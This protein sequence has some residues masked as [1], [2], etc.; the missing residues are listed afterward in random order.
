MPTLAYRAL[1]V[2]AVA[3]LALA[4]GYTAGTKV[5]RGRWL[6]LEVD[7]SNAAAETARIH[8]AAE[9]ARVR[10]VAAHRF[11]T[12]ARVKAA[13]NAH[14]EAPRGCTLSGPERL[15]LDA[16]NAAYAGPAAPGGM[17]TSLPRVATQH[18]GA[19]IADHRKP[20]G[21]GLRMPSAAR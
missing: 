19:R 13:E 18:G 5:E 2:L 7:R 15:R 4:M 9:T 3:A 20:A 17:P 10:D 12:A 8:G 1:A 21:L 6:Q 11:A 16:I 14:P